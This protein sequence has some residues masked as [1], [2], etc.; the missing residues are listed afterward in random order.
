MHIKENITLEKAEEYLEGTETIKEGFELFQ[1]YNQ[2][3]IIGFVKVEGELEVIYP[4]GELT[5]EIDE[6]IEALEKRIKELRSFNEGT[7]EEK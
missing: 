1:E 6:A 4:F 2:S 3:E 7:E 5:K